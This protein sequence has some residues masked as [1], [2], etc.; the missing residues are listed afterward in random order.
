M[1]KSP[2]KPQRIL[3]VCFVLVLSSRS[4]SGQ[5]CELSEGMYAFE[6]KGLTCAYI[7]GVV[8]NMLYTVLVFW[9]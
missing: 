2:C 7:F 1:A 6:Y 5:F 8:G 9:V 4:S 3:N